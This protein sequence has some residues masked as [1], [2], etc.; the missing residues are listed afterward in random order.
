MVSFFSALGKIQGHKC[1]AF[2]ANLGQME[3][4]FSMTPSVKPLGL[5]SATF[6]PIGMLDMG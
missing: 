4:C 2:I 3:E 1:S 5:I 6:A